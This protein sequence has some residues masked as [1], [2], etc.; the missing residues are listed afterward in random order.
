MLAWQRRFDEALRVA[1]LAATV[2]PPG[3]PEIEQAIQQQ[4]K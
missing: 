2:H 3:F 4:M 1:R